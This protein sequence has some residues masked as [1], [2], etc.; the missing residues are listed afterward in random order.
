MW[1]LV[2]A[3]EDG[4]PISFI[5]DIRNLMNYP[6]DYGVASFKGEQWFRS[7]PDPNYWV[8]RGVAVLL[9]VDVV[10][11]EPVTAKWTLP[12]EYPYED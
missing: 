6:E 8:E 4:K 1:I 3:S 7:N 2:K 10:E 12:D 5:H 11:P 9:N